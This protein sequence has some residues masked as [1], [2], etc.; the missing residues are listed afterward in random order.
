MMAFDLGSIH[1]SLKLRL[2]DFMAGLR[3][4]VAQSHR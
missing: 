4:A 2:D 1:A 3:Q